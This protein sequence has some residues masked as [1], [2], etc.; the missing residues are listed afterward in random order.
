MLTSSQ[1]K[2]L[3]R[4]ASLLTLVVT[5]LIFYRAAGV[6]GWQ[7]DVPWH[8]LNGLQTLQT[9]VI[10]TKDTWTWKTPGHAWSNAEWLWDLITAWIYLHLGWFGVRLTVVVVMEL[11]MVSLWRYAR[12]YQP[13]AVL[14]PLALLT[15]TAWIISTEA[16]P[17]IVSYLFFAWALLA[18]E[19]A[20]I[21]Q[22]QRSLWL[23]LPILVLWNNIHGSA[24][25]WLGLLG[26][27]MLFARKESWRYSGI[28]LASIAALLMIPNA[29]AM[30]PFMSHQLT[31]AN[32]AISEWLSPDFH[33][34]S[35]LLILGLGIV[36]VGLIW[37]K[38]T[39]K[40][41]LWLVL[42]WVAY[43]IAIRFSAYA[44]ILTWVVFVRSFKLP[45]SGALNTFLQIIATS[46]IFVQLLTANAQWNTPFSA[47]VEL[48]AAQYCSEHGITEVVNEY[49][50]GGTLEFYGIKTIADGRALWSG[51]L[52]FTQ[53][54]LVHRMDTPIAS[55][56][57]KEAPQIHAVVW[58]DRGLGAYQL[59]RMP[60]WRKVY[61]DKG[62][63]VWQ[64]YP[65]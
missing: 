60:G 20:R 56:L 21:S 33:Q 35:H 25:L 48:G 45:S 50:M 11:L 9:H 14:I 37:S 17:Q 53:Y 2:S 59:D 13:L 63:G 32:L 30:I 7:N 19:K 51:E 12:A 58:E 42:G 27:E 57:Q 31:P 38:T 22:N 3:K 16:R 41:K 47:P 46:A 6:Q 52:W 26:L 64:K 29:F 54:F 34:P 24:V 28:F 10:S 49:S 44:L 40:E 43:F 18:L 15:S 39:L 62:V 8:T 1:T 61:S 36:L 65:S 55:F 5:G 4:I 23:F